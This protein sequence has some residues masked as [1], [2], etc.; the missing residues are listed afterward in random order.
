MCEHIF[1]SHA[2]VG[3]VTR[4]VLIQSDLIIS[5]QDTIV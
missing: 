5:V 2:V 1:S 3:V 4:V